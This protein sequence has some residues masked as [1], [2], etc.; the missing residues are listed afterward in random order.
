MRYLYLAIIAS[1]SGFS[2]DK[3]SVYFDTDR[4][5]LTEAEQ[6]KLVRFLDNPNLKVKKLTGRC[7]FR[8]SNQYNLVLGL[9]RANHILAYFDTLG[10]NQIEVESKGEEFKQDS[11]LALNRRV[12]IDYEVVEPVIVK[13]IPPKKIE[14]PPVNKVMGDLERKFQEAKVG[15][16]I[17]MKNLNFY[18]RSDQF[19]PESVPYLEEL[20]RVMDANPTLKI[21]IQGHI[22]CTPGRDTE[23]FSL[24]RCLA[25]YN[26]LVDYGINSDRMTYVGLDATQPIFPLPEKNEEQR[27]ANRRVEILILEK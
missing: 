2:Q 6:E 11:N 20:Y 15:D 25:V 1:F 3:F 14:I 21:E 10:K 5:V 22:C 7:D 26:F 13:E 9:N 4:Y 19:Y 12:D 18:V 16:K 23:E 24:R 27:K 17:L 8:A